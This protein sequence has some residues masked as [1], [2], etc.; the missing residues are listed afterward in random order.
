MTDM[1]Q[2]EPRASERD[3]DEHVERWLGSRGVTVTTPPTRAT[4]ADVILDSLA[5]SIA[6]R[7][8]EYEPLLSVLRWSLD[9]KRQGA[10][11]LA[12]RP[13][14]IGP[15]TDLATR[16]YRLGL[17]RTYR[18]DRSRRTVLARAS[19][20]GRPFLC[21]GWL[22]RA[23]AGIVS[24]QLPGGEVVRN[25]QVRLPDGQCAELDVVGARDDVLVWVECRSGHVQDRIDR[26]ARLRRRLGV[27]AARAF[28]LGSRLDREQADQLSALHEL[29]F[30]RPCD[31]A[32]ALGIAL[33]EARRL[34]QRDRILRAV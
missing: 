23:A 29:T 9:A 30:V 20:A 14:S 8:E 6:R 33:P 31:L 11:S 3:G 18:Y 25:L 17:L 21:G 26:Y 12:H 5:A 7:V 4:D 16:L 32:A 34:T 19:E 27:A 24:A 1:S 2:H 10:V 13:A 28:V 22:E 15:I